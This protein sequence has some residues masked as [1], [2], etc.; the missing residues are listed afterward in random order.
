MSRDVLV[1]LPPSEGK[2]P[3]ARGPVLKPSKLSFPALAKPRV[4][5]RDA[6]IALCSGSASEAREVL[7]ISARMDAEIERNA[8][9]ST[10]PC[11]PAIDIYS[12]VLYEA[13]DWTSLTSVARKRGQASVAIASAL[14]GLVRPM[15]P[16]PAYRLSGDTSLPPLGR[17]ATVWRDPVAQ[18]IKDEAG[19]GI[20]LDLRSSAYVALGPVPV[21][22]ADRTV[23]ARVLQEK[24]GK[25]VV[26]SHHNKSTKG[27]VVRHLL[28][29]AAPRTVPDAA[30]I[31]GAA[32]LR[33]ELAPPAKDTAPWTLDI[34]T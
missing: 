19:R 34:L 16:I 3:P 11:A 12:G 14:F 4:T 17:L 28:G 30:G 31:L 5:V 27:L 21:D 25:R 33:V 1:L 22:L 8:S 20:V 2:T 15:D 23:V 18:A 26:V 32:G 10:Q 7:G 9:I 24:G 6:L 29:V 13:L